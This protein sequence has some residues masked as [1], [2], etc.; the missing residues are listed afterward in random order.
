M[1][2]AAVADGTVKLASSS[3]KILSLVQISFIGAAIAALVIFRELQR[4]KDE[5]KMQNASANPVLD[6]REDFFND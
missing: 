1:T 4:I 5:Q 2:G 3:V 6:E